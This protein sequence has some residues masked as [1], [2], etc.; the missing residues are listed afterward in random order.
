MDLYKETEQICR[1][2]GNK[3]GLQTSLGNQA[4]ILYDHGDLD[5]AMTLFKE[6][7]R[8][9]RELGNKA[10]LAR[11]LVN[12]ATL[13]ARNLDRPREAL[14]LAE[15]AYR[16]ATQHGLVALARQLQPILDFVRSRSRWPA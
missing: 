2:L 14:P 9:C 10:R 11:S 5:G 16:L 3:D 6:K 7:E 4:G 1:E 12:L 8:I 15:E 13:L